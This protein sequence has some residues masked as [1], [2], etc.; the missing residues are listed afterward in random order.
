MLRV[1]LLAAGKDEQEKD[2][3]QSIKEICVIIPELEAPLEREEGAP[4]T[5]PPGLSAGPSEAACG[6]EKLRKKR[7]KTKWPE[8]QGKE[9]SPELLKKAR[10]LQP[11]LL[12]KRAV[13]LPEKEPAA[14]PSYAV[15]QGASFLSVSKL[16]IFVLQTPAPPA[17]PTAGQNAQLGP[18]PVWVHQPSEAKNAAILQE[19]NF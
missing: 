2:L 4:P 1:R 11:P 19:P 14:G 15:L 5:L 17:T 3:L 9:P 8:T 13:T 7:R 10:F 12:K 16:P 6:T 18:Q